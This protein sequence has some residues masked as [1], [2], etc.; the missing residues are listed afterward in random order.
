MPLDRKGEIGFVQP[1]PVVDD[2]D[3]PPPAGFDR[4][5]DRFRASV[6]RVLDQ[7][8]DRRGRALDHLARGDAVDG[9]GIEA[10]NRHGKL[11]LAADYRIGGRGA[12]A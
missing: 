4:D 1:M 11:D 6:E 8:L 12:K 10:A 7:F 3:E 9:Q 5:F 2:P